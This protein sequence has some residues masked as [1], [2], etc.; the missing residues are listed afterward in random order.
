[1][2]KT[3]LKFL[4]RKATVEIKRKAIKSSFRRF[5]ERWH[6]VA[7]SDISKLGG[8][9]WVGNP[10]EPY[11][12]NW[13]LKPKAAAGKLLDRI[14][15][16]CRR[17]QTPRIGCGFLPPPFPGDLPARLVGRGFRWL[18]EP[19]RYMWLDCHKMEISFAFPAGVTLDLPSDPPIVKAG[20]LPFYSQANISILS[21]LVHQRPQRVFYF[22]LW[23]D[24][25]LIGH[26]TLSVAPGKYG[27]G[28]L[29]DVGVV[30]RTRGR[31]IGT[32]L[33]LEVCRFAEQMGCRYVAANASK[34]GERVY[35]RVGFEVF[36]DVNQYYMWPSVIDDPFT[37]SEVEFAEAVGRGDLGYL[38][39]VRKR[40]KF[41]TP[42]KS[43]IAPLE[44]ATKIAQ[45]YEVCDFLIQMGASPDGSG[46]G[47]WTPLI[48]AAE[49]NVPDIAELLLKNGAQI[50]LTDSEGRDPMSVATER[51]HQ[52]IVELLQSS[53]K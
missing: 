3:K 24:R 5:N 40:E 49:E 22:T 41:A 52:K 39:R 31:G 15:K 12:I 36:C 4:S 9:T 10:G 37:K 51:G 30:P 7:G 11:S 33:T 43:G 46:S 38:K 32:T 14:L 42:I 19:N 35:R 27:V 47:Q 13:P 18:R 6:Q 44:I 8:V 16:Y 21:Q 2:G 29:H 50:D 20:D 23:E 1:M 34:M 48:L 45:S 28:T 53:P 17:L 26:A 25:E